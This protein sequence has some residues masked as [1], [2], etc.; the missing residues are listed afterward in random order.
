MENNR[1]NNKKRAFLNLKNIL[2]RL[3]MQEAGWYLGFAPHAIPIL[4][5]AGLL[6]P[7]GRPAANEVKYFAM[8]SL[9]ELR[10]DTQWLERASDALTRY[11]QYKNGRE[12]SLHSEP[13]SKAVSQSHLTS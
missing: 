11:W 12:S 7:L 4:I 10:G 9:A 3:E 2:A 5:R 8:A 1:M 13:A 6:K